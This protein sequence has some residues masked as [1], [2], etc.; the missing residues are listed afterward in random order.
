MRIYLNT[1]LVILTMIF[2]LS[3]AS[4]QIKQAL[5]LKN[6]ETGEVWVLEKGKKFYIE[7]RPTE[8]KPETSEY[9]HRYNPLTHGRTKLVGF[10]PDDDNPA[11]L[12]KAPRSLERGTVIP[13]SS[14]VSI[15]NQTR[16]QERNTKIIRA[17][18]IPGGLAIAVVGAFVGGPDGVLLA[19][20]GASITGLGFS[21]LLMKRKVFRFDQDST[22]RI[23][24]LEN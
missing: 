3:S 8:D 23:I 24:T 20:L 2:F 13:L 14:L 19:G 22:V 21:T 5:E 15:G 16:N 17:I 4:A 18:Y 11:V 9:N 6:L 12:I 1:S 10:L 7:A